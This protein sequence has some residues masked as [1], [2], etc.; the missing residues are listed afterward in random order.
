MVHNNKEV[1]EYWNKED[2]ESMYDKFLIRAEIELIK[3]HIPINSKVLDAGCGEGEGTLEYAKIK[4]LRIHAA[5]FSTTRLKKA[6]KRLKDFSNVELFQI[7]FLNKYDLDYDYDVIISQRFLINLM[8]L[9]IQKRVIKELIARINSG[10]Y[11]LIFEGS[12]DGV[13]ELNNFRKLFGLKPIL[14]KWHNLFFN[15]SHLENFLIKEGMEIVQK[16]GLGDYFFLTRGIRP[17][18]ETDLSWNSKYNKTASSKALKK[19][20][21]LGDRFSR[22]KLWVCKKT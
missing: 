14:I 11:F 5:D 3:K 18:F 17:Y 19:F 2:V 8:E 12:V 6:K 7:D 4:N 16:E 21:H 9:D 20:L 13:N 1:L 22:L 15:D 10:G